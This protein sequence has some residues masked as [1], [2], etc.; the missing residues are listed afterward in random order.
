MWGCNQSAAQLWTVRSD[1]R[2]EVLGK[3]M[4]VSG[5]GAADG[6]SIVLY[7]CGTA[8]SQVWRPQTNGTLLNPV[9][10]RCLNAP[11]SDQDTQL[12]LRTCS[13]SANQQ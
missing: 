7:D 9:F 2:L 8:G 3:C 4:T 12:T 5:D 13:V 1:G 11:S 6:T 10:G